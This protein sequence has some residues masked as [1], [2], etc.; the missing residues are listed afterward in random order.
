MILNTSIASLPVS[1]EFLDTFKPGQFWIWKL[2]SFRENNSDSVCKIINAIHDGAMKIETDMFPVISQEHT[3][4][5][6]RNIWSLGDNGTLWGMVRCS[7]NELILLIYANKEYSHIELLEDRTDTNGNVSF[8]YLSQIMPCIFL[9]HH[10]LTFHSA[11][12]EHHGYSFALCADSGVGKTT[13][14]RLW[15]DYKNALILNGDRTVCRR[16]EDNWTAYGTPW[17]GTSGEQINR[18]APLRAMVIVERADEKRMDDSSDDMIRSADYSIGENLVRRLTPAE[19]LPRLLPH[20]LYPSWDEEL[21]NIAFTEL[22]HLL[23]TIP[24]LLFRS[25]PDEQAID[26]LETAL[27]ELI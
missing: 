14:A 24:V 18:S 27:E 23:R 9:K 11:L 15:R 21:I 6:L 12:I 2:D 22:D 13:R 5:F 1:F 19:A 16:T 17:S 26:L 20:M 10:H 4:F 7:S 3:G 25:H 8:E